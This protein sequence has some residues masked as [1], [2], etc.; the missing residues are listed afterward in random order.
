MDFRSSFSASAVILQSLERYFQVVTDLF[1]AKNRVNSE[2]FGSISRVHHRSVEESEQARFR[3]G[4]FKTWLML[5]MDFPCFGAINS[6]WLGRLP[7]AAKELTI[8]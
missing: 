8:G 4:Q 7:L 6:F 3:F 1:S 5:S 2:T